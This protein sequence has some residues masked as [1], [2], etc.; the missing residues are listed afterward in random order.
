MDKITDAKT[1]FRLKQWTQII[2]T[3]QASGMTVV[4]WCSQ[5]NVNIKSYY[6]WLQRVRSLICE[7][8]SLV[9]QRKDQQIVPISFNQAKAAAVTIHLSSVSIDVQD[10]T[11][12]ETVEA[13]LAAL[14][15]IC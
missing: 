4:G 2:Q 9:P 11:S 1:E 13:V 14:K 12:R 7:S 15:T 8:G 10:G 3:C 5:N 6:Y